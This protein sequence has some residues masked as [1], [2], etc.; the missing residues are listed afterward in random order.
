MNGPQNLHH[1]IDDL[2]L[3]VHEAEDSTFAFEFDASDANLDLI[4]TELDWIGDFPDDGSFGGDGDGKFFDSQGP[5]D[6]GASFYSAP[7]RAAG[8]GTAFVPL[9]LPPLDLGF[10]ADPKL[11]GDASLIGEVDENLRI[12]ATQKRK[13]PPIDYAKHFFAK[14]SCATI[15]LPVAGSQPRRAPTHTADRLQRRKAALERAA[16]YV[17]ARLVAAGASE[18]RARVTGA[19]FMKVSAQLTVAVHPDCAALQKALVSA[20]KSGANGS[21]PAAYAD[22]DQ[23]IRRVRGTVSRY[24]SEPEGLVVQLVNASKQMTT[25]L[26]G[27]VDQVV[28]L[29]LAAL[30]LPEVRRDFAQCGPSLVFAWQLLLARCVVEHGIPAGVAERATGILPGHWALTSPS[31]GAL[32]NCSA[33]DLCHAPTG[34]L[35]C[36]I[37]A[38]EP[39]RGVAT[40]APDVL[41]SALLFRFDVAL[42][43]QAAFLWRAIESIGDADAEPSLRQAVQ[44]IMIAFSSI[45]EAEGRPECQDAV[46]AVR[47][48][49][50]LHNFIETSYTR[51]DL[52][53]SDVS[54]QRR[55]RAVS[56]VLGNNSRN[57]VAVVSALYE[58]ASAADLEAALQVEA[59]DANRERVRS[60]LMLPADGSMPA[61]RTM[62]LIPMHSI[63]L[64]GVLSQVHTIV[65]KY[66][67]VSSDAPVPLK[68]EGEPFEFNRTFWSTVLPVGPYY[69]V[70]MLTPVAKFSRSVIDWIMLSEYMG[71]V[72]SSKVQTYTAP[73]RSAAC[74]QRSIAALMRNPNEHQGVARLRHYDVAVNTMNFL[75]HIGFR[76]YFS[77]SSI[78]APT[79]LFRMLG[80]AVPKFF[81]LLPYVILGEEFCRR[82]RPFSFNQSAVRAVALSKMGLMFQDLWI[83]EGR[84]P[85]VAFFDMIVNALAV[86]CSVFC[87]R[88][89]RKDRV[90]SP[91]GHM[92]AGV[93]QDLVAELRRIQHSEANDEAEQAKCGEFADRLEGCIDGN[94]ACVLRD[95]NLADMVF[96]LYQNSRLPLRLDVR[97]R[98]IRNLRLSER[99]QRTYLSDITSTHRHV[100]AHKTFRNVP[101]IQVTMDKPSANPVQQMLEPD[102]S[103]NV[104][105]PLGDFTFGTLFILWR[106]YCGACQ[107]PSETCSAQW[108]QYA[109]G[110]VDP[111]AIPHINVLGDPASS[112]SYGD[113]I[114]V[115]S[116]Y[117][118]STRKHA[119]DVDWGSTYR[120]AALSA[121]AAAV[122]YHESGC[123]KTVS[124][125]H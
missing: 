31:F 104:T 93:A 66:L 81:S 94:G 13:L 22:V 39:P 20:L 35:R 3:L 34:P 112:I 54:A 74:M 6:F 115:R 117:G 124:K 108:L 60:S 122:A 56:S 103:G 120:S 65:S 106:S 91:V 38:T 10:P 79:T 99:T 37:D 100:C 110:Q 45:E 28:L 41:V 113:S 5:A 71:T 118:E 85:A 72:K 24:E 63:D 83:T 19:D 121:G 101:G 92:P 84:A 40:L 78:F 67:N 57:R 33:I 76:D 62:W 105:V 68:D 95:S 4:D 97:I 107:M 29:L 59:D 116:A 8:A 73:L 82:D 2:G 75:L 53:A 46:R 52:V 25:R 89:T 49:A 90:R 70:S 23:Y 47:L 48:A 87:N 96:L 51:Q 98:A 7:P 1:L 58:I 123:W 30:D 80:S 44:Q 125:P 36:V 43:E 11:S 9:E 26:T 15:S 109:G 14:R 61:D 88:T 111:D 16:Q 119:L 21:K 114:M 102:A 64:F 77:F 50:Y 86:L 69:L 27:P 18:E 12:E 17:S 55:Q 42:H 32:A